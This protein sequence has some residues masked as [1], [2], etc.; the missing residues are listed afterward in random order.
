MFNP[1]N[2]Y[3]SEEGGGAGNNWAKGY[4]MAETI[5][6]DIMDMI[7][8]EVDGADSLEGFCLIHS[9]AGGTGS[10]TGSYFL[11][12][13]TDRFEKKLIQTYSVFPEDSE[14]VV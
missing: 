4:H 13:L 5:S 10:G 8:R 2:Y 14:V 6:E 9:I 7:D 12:R 11:E 1:E 3:L